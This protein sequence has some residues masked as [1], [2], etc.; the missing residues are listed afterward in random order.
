MELHTGTPLSRRSSCYF[1]IKKELH[2]VSLAKQI[3]Q[4]SPS[5]LHMHSSNRWRSSPRATSFTTDA[6]LVC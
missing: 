5:L 4:S 2:G 1:A 6:S 3:V